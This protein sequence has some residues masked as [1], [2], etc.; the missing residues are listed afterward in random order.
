[1]QGQA[2]GPSDHLPVGHAYEYKYLSDSLVPLADPA[3]E[4]IT[5]EGGEG[6]QYQDYMGGNWHVKHVF[7]SAAYGYATLLPSFC[8]TYTGLTG[9]DVIAVSAAKG[10][11][12]IDY[13]MP[14]TPAFRFIAEKLEGARRASSDYEITGTYVVW[15][16]GESDAIESTGREEYRQ[17]LA[18]FGHALRDTLGVDRFG[19]IRCGYFTGDERDLQ[20]IGA[21]DDIC[22]EDPFFLML[23]E[24]MTTL[25]GM[26]EYMNPFAAGHLNTRGLERIGHVSAV[27]LAESLK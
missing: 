22:K 7:G 3:G 12:T 11:T 25:N 9:K 6:E 16:Q 2:E 10:A 24:Q 19:V 4:D 20:I 14:G 23:T 17:K 26:P 1:M 8:R 18:V 13:W 15:L 21:Q 27:T 5:Y